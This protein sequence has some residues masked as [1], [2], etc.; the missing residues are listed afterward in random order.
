MKNVLSMVLGIPSKFKKGQK[1]TVCLSTGCMAEKLEPVYEGIII[2]KSKI[3]LK[4]SKRSHIPAIDIQVTNPLKSGH[5]CLQKK[6]EIAD[7]LRTIEDGR[8][9]IVN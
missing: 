8:L 3:E 4:N 6:T 5:K 2:G 9:I 1:I 7:R